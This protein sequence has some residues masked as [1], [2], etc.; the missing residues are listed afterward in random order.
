MV[1][2]PYREDRRST[3][4]RGYDYGKPGAYF[5]TINVQGTLPLLGRVVNGAVA[6]SAAGLMVE[7]TWRDTPLV[8]AA[9]AID[10]FVVM[11]DHFQGIVFVRPTE[12]SPAIGLPDVVGRFKSLTTSRYIA[13]VRDHGW[14]RFKGR[15][16]QRNYHD[17]TIRNG[18]ELTFVRQYLADNPR[19]WQNRMSSAS[20]T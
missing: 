19:E 18:Q 15:L 7:R 20:T 1:W 11:P 5:V 3:R 12:H 10:E 17:R 9:I 16:W 13:G 6:L 8:H 4:L 2:D 14:T